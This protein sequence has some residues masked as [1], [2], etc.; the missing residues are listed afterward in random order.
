[1]VFQKSFKGV[2]SFKGV[3][4]VFQG[5]KEVKRMVQGSMALFLFFMRFQLKW[6]FENRGDWRRAFCLG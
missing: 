4:R 6:P 5:C 3:S 2:R 1:M